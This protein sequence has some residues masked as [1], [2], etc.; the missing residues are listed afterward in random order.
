MTWGRVNTTW[1][2]I[3][4]GSVWRT[5]FLID[6]IHLPSISI[7]SMVWANT[8]ITTTCTP[9]TWRTVV[10]VFTEAIP[11]PSQEYLLIM[12]ISHLFVAPLLLHCY[13]PSTVKPT[14]LVM[15]S[16]APDIVSNLYLITMEL[17]RVAWKQKMEIHDPTKPLGWIEFDSGKP[18]G[19]GE[20]THSLRGSMWLGKWDSFAYT[21]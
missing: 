15:A 19:V 10:R 18:F 5:S 16:A 4:W 1:P 11:D 8:H 12:Y 17:M 3:L 9:W 2:R 7:L 20:C 13:F 6:V 21:V 14:V